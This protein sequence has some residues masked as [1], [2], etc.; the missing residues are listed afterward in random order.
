[1]QSS[2][3]N[4]AAVNG[5]EAACLGMPWEDAYGHAQAIKVRNKIHV[6]GQLSRE[7][8]GTDRVCFSR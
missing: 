2:D 1:M 7:N 3:I 5:K 4:A 6:S 8:K